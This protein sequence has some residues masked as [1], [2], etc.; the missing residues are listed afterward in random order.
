MKLSLRFILPLAIVLSALAYGLIPLVDKLTLQWAIRDLN[1]R[2]KLVVSTMEA[3]LA[4][5]LISESK[6]K[7]L[8][9]FHRVI[10]DERLY[11]L[12]FCDTR[13]R[14]VYKT[15]TYPDMIKC[16]DAG[17]SQTDSTA[18]V[19]LSQGLVHVTSAAIE[20][21]G[22]PLGRLMLI[23][24]MSWIQR[25]SEDT[26]WYIFYLFVVLGAVISL[27]TVFVAHLSW[28]GWVAGVRGI[29]R[30]ESL[31][32]PVSEAQAPE[33]LPVAQDLRALIHDLEADRRLRDESQMS[34]KPAALRT[35]LHE[36]LA[37]D[38]VLIISNREPYIHTRRGS[39][40]DVQV[41]ASGLVTALEPVMRACSGVWIAHGSGT[42]DREVVD[43]R[44]HVR[45]PPDKPAYDIR[46]VWMSP[47]EE[48]G[49]YYGF[50][51]EG[52]WPLCHIAH[53]R[54]VFRSSDWKQYV[55]I[56]E[57]FAEVVREEAKTDNPVV[58]VQD[59]H[60]ALLP[61]LIKDRLPNATI[62]TFWHIPWPNAE[63]YGIC[64]W[65]AEILEGLLGS[66][67]LG[68]H[69]RVHC[70]NFLDSVDRL[71]EARIDRNDSTISYGSKLTA[72]NPYPISIEWPVRWVQDQK[73]VPDCR[74]HIRTL[75]GIEPGRLIGVGVDRLDYTKGIPERFRAVERLLELKPEWIGKFSFIQIAAPSRS[76]IEEYQHFK[77]QVTTLA[78]TINKRF[79][80]DGYQPIYL[81]VVHHDPPDTF[82]YYRGADLCVVSSLHDGMNLVAKEYVA[83]R[84]DEQGVLILSQF[85]GASHELPE[86]LVVNPYDIDQCA[87][88]L[89]R[90]LTMP[91]VEQ[92]AR[93]R[94]MRALIREFNVYR[95]AGRMLMDAA[96]I[97]QR[98]RVMQQ[99][100][101]S[102]TLL[103]SERR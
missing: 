76:V 70:N 69:T 79:G 10:Q 58:L 71:L 100:R 101:R 87:A 2:S 57:R 98:E 92:R 95:W 8:A 60:L 63:R 77:E 21:N 83:A 23:H 80:R 14:L 88:A 42:A 82:A 9:Y 29:L 16:R 67:I 59:Y 4:D 19:Q 38:E 39:T 25:R 96:R 7:L 52:L 64:P 97:R 27:V 86:A 44:D 66:N 46:R 54:P 24:D 55:A 78:E 68:F 12:G 90:A 11:A 91:P 72:V 32:T 37:G 33:F 99:V 53:I 73:P 17:T 18:V 84:D 3:P 45:V 50:S 85:T 5:L 75:N 62:I 34:W 41:P 31:L 36:Q 102:D 40:I 56:N 48:V 35:I 61:K 30:G 94:N 74:A 43:N 22:K 89:H 103:R 49:Y 51:N 65:S 28:K 81:K 93:M 6:S 47:E 20:G 1:I 26:K 13:N 15:Q